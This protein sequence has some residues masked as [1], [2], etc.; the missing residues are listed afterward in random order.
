[1]CLAIK[2]DDGV[3][4]FFRGQPFDHD[5]PILSAHSQGSAQAL[6]GFQGPQ[7]ITISD[8]DLLYAC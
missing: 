2:G 4:T 7:K 3:I 1:M 8:Y 6:K 5:I